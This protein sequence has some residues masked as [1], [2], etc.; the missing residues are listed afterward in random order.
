MGQPGDSLGCRPG[1]QPCWQPQASTMYCCLIVLP[2]IFQH[3]PTFTTTS[4]YFSSLATQA[5]A[6]DG[7]DVVMWRRLA[8]LALASSQVALARC[9]CEQALRISPHHPALLDILHAALVLA[10]DHPAAQVPF[11]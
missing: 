5:S 11:W 3:G 10:G 2:D 8:S 9:A 6:L 7:S 4:I 1:I